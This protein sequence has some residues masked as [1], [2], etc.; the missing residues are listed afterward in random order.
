MGQRR[1]LDRHGA[2]RVV[3]TVVGSGL[4]NGQKLDKFE[5]HFCDPINKLAQRRDIADSQILLAAQGKQRYE[6]AC[7]FFSGDK[8]IDRKKTNGNE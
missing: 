1:W 6:N 3:W 7:D 2:D 8:F 5:S 4:V